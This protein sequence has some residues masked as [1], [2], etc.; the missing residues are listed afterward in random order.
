MD[1]F[2]SGSSALPLYIYIIYSFSAGF[3]ELAA[4]AVWPT[5]YKSSS[6]SIYTRVPPSNR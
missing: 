3:F 2:A 1:G 6:F 5:L 4:A